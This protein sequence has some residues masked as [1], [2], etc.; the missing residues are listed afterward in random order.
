MFHHVSTFCAVHVAQ[1][2]V[3]TQAESAA[4]C[5]TMRGRRRS[6]ASLSLAQQLEELFVLLRR[7]S[8]THKDL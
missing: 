6:M 1:K 5:A 2:V 7:P 8:P 4:V 3:F